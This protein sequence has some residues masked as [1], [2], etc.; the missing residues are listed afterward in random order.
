[1]R[2]MII[3]PGDAASEAGGTGSERQF[4]DM[5]SYNEE[6]LRAGVFVAGEGLHPTA[7]GA[8][9][10]WE[11]DDWVVT[12]GPFAEAK[13]LIAGFTIIEVSS[14]EEAVEWVKK[15]PRSCVPGS[16]QALEL[17]QVYSPEDFAE[18]LSPELFARDAR[19]RE[20]AARNAARG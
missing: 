16:G 7:K 6:M 4:A 17:R 20:E 18:A 1:M 3:V 15:W 13:E 5:Q 12:D 19:M 8:Q 2:F 10:T 9:V 14:R 11:D